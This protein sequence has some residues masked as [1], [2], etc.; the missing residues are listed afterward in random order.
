LLEA[1]FFC[2]EQVTS[3]MRKLEKD[4]CYYRAEMFG[5]HYP[6]I[7]ILTIEDLQNHK[8]PLIAR[9]QENKV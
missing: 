3:E 2:E 9:K 1:A 8:Q 6:K 7:Q 4:A 5:N